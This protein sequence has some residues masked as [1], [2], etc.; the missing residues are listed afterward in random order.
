M[1]QWWGEWT[2]IWWKC[3]FCEVGSFCSIEGYW[4]WLGEVVRVG[5]EELSIESPLNFEREGSVLVPD[6]CFTQASIFSFPS[7]F[8]W[9]WCLSSLWPW[10]QPPSILPVKYWA[11]VN[12]SSSCSATIVSSLGLEES[13]WGSFS[14]CQALLLSLLSSS[15]HK[16]HH[17]EPFPF[18]L[19]REDQIVRRRLQSP[20]AGSSGGEGF[21]G[22]LWEFWDWVVG[23]ALMSHMC[24]NSPLPL[25]SFSLWYHY[26]PISHHQHDTIITSFWHHCD[27]ITPLTPLWYHSTYYDLTLHHYDLILLHYDTITP[28]YS[29]YIHPRYSLVKT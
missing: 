1:E 15:L 13:F 24:Y 8:W 6:R 22:L 12:T 28:M 9:I 4:F 21:W 7:L 27:V 20:I 5:V 3:G 26:N 19:I 2:H 17:S 25:S 10:S 18:S 11:Q 23:P 14:S 16:I 29:Y